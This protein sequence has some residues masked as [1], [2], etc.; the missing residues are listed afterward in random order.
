[1]I[2]AVRFIVDMFQH[3]VLCF[4]AVYLLFDRF[5]ALV[6]IKFVWLVV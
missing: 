5:F 2:N 6:V 1:M 3:I 4:V